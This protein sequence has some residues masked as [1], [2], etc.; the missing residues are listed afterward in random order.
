MSSIAASDPGTAGSPMSSPPVVVISGDPLSAS[1][2]RQA[3]NIAGV[4]RV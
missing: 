1:T 4:S 3:A 2:S